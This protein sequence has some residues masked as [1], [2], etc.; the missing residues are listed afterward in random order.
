MVIS[1]RAKPDS[2]SA[3]KHT[4][5]DFLNTCFYYRKIVFT[6]FLIVAVLGCTLA[7]LMPLPYRAQAT[8][9]VLYAGYYDQSSNTQGALL[10]PPVGQLVS[11][12]AQI[13]KSPELQ[14]NVV[15]SEMGGKADP[16]VLDRRLE[17]FNKRFHIEQNDL[18]NT[19]KLSYYDDNP[20]KAVESL[21]DLLKLYFEQRAVVFTSGRTGMLTDLRDQARRNLDSA[22]N[23]LIEFQKTHDAV[24]IEEQ[25]SRAVALESLLVQRKMEN[26]AALAQDR[27]G[28]EALLAATRDVKPSIELFTDNSEEMRAQATMRLSL[29]ELEARRAEFATRYMESS[30]FV[31]QLDRQIAE[32]RAGLAKQ[33]ASS[34]VATR[35]GHNTYYD[36]VQDKIASLSSSI[37]GEEARQIELQGQVEEMRERL[38]KLISVSNQLRQ[39]QTERDILA[40]TFRDRSRQLEQAFSQEEQARAAHSTNVRVIEAPQIPTR[41]SIS[42]AMMAAASLIAALVIAALVGLVLSTLRETFLSPEQV[43]RE[44]ALRVLSAPISRRGRAEGKAQ[45]LSARNAHQTYGPIAAKIQALPGAGSHIVMAMSYGNDEGCQEVVKGLAAELA[46]R[47]NKPVLILDLAPASASGR[48]GSPDAQGAITWADVE[49]GDAL[50][51]K[52]DEVLDQDTLGLIDVV[53]V[54]QHNIWVARPKSDAVRLSKSQMLALLQQLRTVADYVLI[55]APPLSESLLGVENA[56]RVDA[57]V[58]VLRAEATRTPVAQMLKSQVLDANGNILGVALTNRRVYIPDFVYRLL[59][60]PSRNHSAS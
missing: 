46:R 33:K 26:D 4:L 7:W 40:D 8:L 49:P 14:R 22:T 19:I 21:D 34:S 6:V 51:V 47:S 10:A 2:R 12:E 9:L 28:L 41:R 36:T 27:S 50:P 53:A 30:P 23:A 24:N 1:T 25:I 16:V 32:M 37:A 15:L 35:R 20:T 57:I 17:A 56:A 29:M 11:V 18:A 13:L 42:F 44:L 31:Q 38:R 39:M 54:A 52:A 5:R 3:A 58:L 59:S 48:Y 45:R 55:D 60:K 43:E